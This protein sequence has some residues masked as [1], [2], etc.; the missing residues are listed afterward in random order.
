LL[1]FFTYGAAS[2]AFPYL[3]EAME[4]L[5]ISELRLLAEAFAGAGLWRESIRITAEYMAREDYEITRRDMELAFP[6]PFA[7]IIE[8]VSGEEG[9]PPE[10]LFGLIRTESAFD[11]DAVSRVGAVGLAQLMPATALDMARRISRQ[12]G[13]DYA[14]AGEPDLRDPRVNLPL[15]ARY[16]RYLWDRLGSPML[17]LTAYNGGMGRISRWRAAAGDLSEDL[18]PETIEYSETR[19]YGRKVLAAAAAYGYLY[20]DMSMEEVLADIYK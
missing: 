10:I 3:G 9:L 19:N 8:G 14:E 7:E 1:D 2:H 18:F 17:A 20:Y 13:P 6:R 11:A 16:L 12:G 5:T 15:G 4:D